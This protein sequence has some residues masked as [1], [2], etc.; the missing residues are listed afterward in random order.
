MKEKTICAK[1]RTKE[2]SNAPY[3]IC[4]VLPNSSKQSKKAEFAEVGKTKPRGFKSDRLR[5]SRQSE[6]K[7]QNR[8]GVRMGLAKKKKHTALRRG[9][10]VR[11]TFS[12]L[13]TKIESR[14]P[15]KCCP[16]AIYFRSRSRSISHQ[17]AKCRR[18]N[19]ARICVFYRESCYSARRYS[20]Y[21][22]FAL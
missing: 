10:I 19:E 16:N 20:P 11:R 3:I 1:S 2:K 18:L 21:L 4:N 17:S 6:N 13:R 9:S 12:C 14:L 8:T 5:F 7:T 22:P 15:L